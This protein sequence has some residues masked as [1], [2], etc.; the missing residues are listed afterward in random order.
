MAIDDRMT[1]QSLAR[2]K[3]HVY[4]VCSGAAEVTLL[5]ANK[6]KDEF[7]TPLNE[8]TLSLK[9]FPVRFNPYDRKVTEKIAWADDTDILCYI[10]KLQLDNSSLTIQMLRKKYKTMRYDKKTYDI[11]YIEPYS[12]FL[13][14]FL[15]VVIGGKS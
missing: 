5:S 13:N 11:R 10:P 15:Y 6:D 2:A 12:A 8:T 14:D 3:L 4:N 1:S 7:G 9:T